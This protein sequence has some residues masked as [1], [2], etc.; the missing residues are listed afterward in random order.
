ML[1]TDPDDNW[2]GFGQTDR[3]H[4]YLDPI[5]VTILTPGMNELGTLEEEDPGGAGG[6]V[7]RRARHRG[8]EDR[9]VQPAVPVQHRHRQNQ[10]AQPAARDDRLQTLVRS[11]PAGENMLPSLYQEAPDFYENMRI[12]D[13]AQN[14]HRLVEQHNLPDLMYRAFEVLPTMVMNPYQAFQKEL[15]GEVEEVYLEEMVGKVNANMILPYPPG[16]PLV[17]PGEMLTEESRPV[18]EFLADAVRNRRALSG[19]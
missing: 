17:M 13:L 1:A 5:K 9:A 4:M 10:G 19:L 6:E 16:V 15:H 14:I 18:L 3:D 12:Q 8:G 11:E 7:P 2:H